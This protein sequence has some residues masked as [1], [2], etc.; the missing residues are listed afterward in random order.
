MRK[1]V[2]FVEN[3]KKEKWVQCE[4][5]PV[6]RSA[7]NS[8]CTSNCCEFGP[9]KRVRKYDIGITSGNKQFYFPKYMTT[10]P[11]LEQHAS[12]AAGKRRYLHSISSI[13]STEQMRRQMKQHYLD[14][15]HSCLQSG[16]I[17]VGRRRCGDLQLK[18]NQK[19]RQ[20]SSEKENGAR[21]KPQGRRVTQPNIRLP[22]IVNRQ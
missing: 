7:E 10:A 18:Q 3:L 12:L 11:F 6:T 5:A 4:Q 2:T 19:F 13:Y 16:Q 15:L 1:Q 22:K 20:E 17:S 14:V 8:S 21:V 9:H